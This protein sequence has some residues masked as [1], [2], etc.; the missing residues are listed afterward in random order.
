[1][2]FTETG[3][4]DVSIT[5]KGTKG[6][7]IS[8]NGNEINLVATNE[9]VEQAVPGLTNTKVKYITIDNNYQFGVQLGQ[10]SG[11]VVTQHGLTDYN[12]FNELRKAVSFSLVFE[13]VATLEY[14][15]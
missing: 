8:R 5:L 9:A 15:S 7:R 6:V 14:G 11:H 12:E 13:E 3:Q 1:L 2:K 10:A 4:S